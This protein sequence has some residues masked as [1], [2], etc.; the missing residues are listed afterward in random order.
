MINV[1]FK[2]LNHYEILFQKQKKS[3]AYKTDYDN[4]R[5]DNFLP[6]FASAHVSVRRTFRSEE[7]GRYSHISVVGSVPLDNT[8]LIKDR[9]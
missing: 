2:Y 3:F 6:A 7:Q 5:V 8:V 1:T 9:R 4:S